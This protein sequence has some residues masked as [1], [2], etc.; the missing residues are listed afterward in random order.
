M[1]QIKEMKYERETNMELG[2]LICGIMTSQTNVLLLYY[3]TIQICQYKMF[4]KN[5]MWSQPNNCH[6]TDSSSE[7]KPLIFVI[8]FETK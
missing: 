7:D 4:V 5:Q 1:L 6:S 2:I 3:S 8:V